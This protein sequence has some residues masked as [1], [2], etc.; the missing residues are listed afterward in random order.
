[1]KHELKGLDNPE[2]YHDPISIDNQDIDTLKNMLS[3]CFSLG[4][5]NNS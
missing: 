1:M 3:I 4:K 5:L 2:K